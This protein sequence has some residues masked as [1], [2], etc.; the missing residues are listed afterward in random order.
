M[1]VHRLPLES[2]LGLLAGKVFFAFILAAEG[3]VWWRGRGVDLS[4]FTPRVI[5]VLKAK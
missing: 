5:W 1:R 3:G 4:S 2:R